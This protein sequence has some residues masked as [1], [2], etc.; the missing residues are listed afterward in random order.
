MFIHKYGLLVLDSCEMVDGTI[1][2]F[3]YFGFLK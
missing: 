1:F 2:F 3:L